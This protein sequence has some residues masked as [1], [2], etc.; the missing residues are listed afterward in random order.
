MK[1]GCEGRRGTDCFADVPILCTPRLILRAFTQYWNKGLITEAIGVVTD[2]GLT[3]L[4]L[5]RIQALV[6]P[7]N[8][9]SI[10]ALEKSGYEQEGILRKYR[11]GKEFHDATMLAIIRKENIN[12][13]K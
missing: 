1:R 13:K 8:K 12:V 6:M 9:A 3:R 5:H 11:F 7:P 2:L 10:R 4:L